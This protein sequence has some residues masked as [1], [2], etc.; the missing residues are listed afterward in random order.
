MR[1]EYKRD[2]NHNYLILHSEMEVDT[3]AYQVRMLVSNGIPSLLKC[4]LQG[5]DGETLFSYEITSKQSVQT[6]FEEK[7]LGIKELK[8]IFGGFVQA[9]E[10]MGEYL[11]NPG[12]LLIQPEY[13]YLDLEKGDTYFC[14]LPGFD[15]EVRDQFRELTEYMLPKLD[16]TDE[17][18]VILG[19][20]VYRRALEEHFHLEHI[21]EELYRVHGEQEAPRMEAVP[22]KIL[23]K[24]EEDPGEEEALKGNQEML[25]ETG[26][27]S[28]EEWKEKENKETEKTRKG[29]SDKK[30]FKITVLVCVLAVLA[31]LGIFAANILGYLPWIEIEWLLGGVL[32]LTGS[33]LLG[34]T[35]FTKAKKRKKS[36]EGKKEVPVFSEREEFRR[37]VPEQEAPEKRT[38]ERTEEKP[39]EKTAEKPTPTDFGETVVLSEMKERGPASLVSREPGE[40][41]TIYLKEE[42]TVVGKLE[43]ASDAVIPLPTVSRI[44]ARIRQ[45]EGEYFLTDL[46]SRNGTSVNG[47]MLKEEEEYMLQ[48]E[49]EVDFA[50]ARYVFLK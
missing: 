2:V 17:K 24:V 20:G 7:K 45:R 15:R 10:E 5:V 13:M 35:V 12:N 34:Y 4:R 40:L 33:A 1:T 46:N 28:V 11:L 48:N 38:T 29:N 37:F 9:I 8:M 30:R 6:L 27:T 23:R 44:H 47:R 3:S 42:I 16:H 14:Y 43:T 25:W 41:A 39:A 36:Q 32:L 18:A 21:K 26:L 50:Q 31:I 19:Y 49:D 22:E